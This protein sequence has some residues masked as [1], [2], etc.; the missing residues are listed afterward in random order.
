MKQAYRQRALNRLGQ[1][2][3]S[4]DFDAREFALFQVA[5]M[6]RRSQHNR[7]PADWTNYDSEQLPRDLLRIR[8]SPADQ[9]QIAGQLRQMMKTF[10]ESRASAF[11]AL[12]E[13]SAQVGF[14]AAA[15][16]IAEQGN[17][18]DDEAAYQACQ[19]MLL[20][21]ESGGVAASQARQL[22]ADPASLGA[23]SRWSRSTDTRLAKIANDLI[24]RAQLCAG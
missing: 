11:W 4:I 21:L 12:T 15:S 6:L 18:L 2:L 13:A 1:D 8:L 3:A 16:A 20:W 22:L 17:H 10:P 19:A 14:T 7:A 23:L 9:E 24:K 5:M